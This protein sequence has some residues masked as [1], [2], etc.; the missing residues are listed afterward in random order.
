M[1]QANPTGYSAD[2]KL[3]LVI[4]GERVLLSQVAP[5]FV[6]A[7]APVQRRQP[8]DA[9]VVVSVD[10]RERSRPV[11]LIDGIDP[12]EVRTQIRPREAAIAV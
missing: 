4:D 10:G 1:G 2:V 8:C 9:Y 6:I 3:W 11:R 5:T 7:K 12:G